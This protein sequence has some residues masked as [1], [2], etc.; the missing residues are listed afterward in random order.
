MTR[1]QEQERLQERLA[2]QERHRWRQ[3]WLDQ[4][5]RGEERE[6]RR[7]DSV[8]ARR[9]AEAAESRR[10]R[11]ELQQRHSQSLE[12]LTALIRGREERAANE[13]ATQ[14]GRKVGTSA[15]SG[16]RPTTYSGVTFE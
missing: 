5:R 4:L 8:L 16:S 2:E 11:E 7:V 12:N 15:P 3:E 10:R 14:R 9:T 13:L 6:E 1:R